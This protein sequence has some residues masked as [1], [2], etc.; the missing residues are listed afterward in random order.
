M[1]KTN[2]AFVILERAHVFLYQFSLTPP[3]LLFSIVPALD[4]VTQ[5]AQNLPSCAKLNVLK[6]CF[7]LQWTGKADSKRAI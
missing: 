7:L 6:Q 4:S 1:S 5:R 2:V 3:L